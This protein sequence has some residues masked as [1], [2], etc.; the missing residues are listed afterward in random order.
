MLCWVRRSQMSLWA[1]GGLCATGSHSRSISFHCDRG[2]QTAGLLLTPLPSWL[3][4]PLA[5]ITSRK[6]ELATK[7]L[8]FSSTLEYVF[9]DP[10]RCS[11]LSGI[12]TEAPLCTRR[13]GS[14]FIT[15]TLYPRSLVLV[16]LLPG[17]TGIKDI[18]HK[19]RWVWCLS[20]QWQNPRW[21]K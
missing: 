17:P 9:N 15:M 10:S 6:R 14:S 12:L 21:L 18:P 2:G 7:L 16:G 4:I 11:W 5:S 1:M 19:A 20:C 13:E 8:F 3:R